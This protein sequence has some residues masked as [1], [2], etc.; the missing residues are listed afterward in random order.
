MKYI[1]YL[2]VCENLYYIGMTNNFLRRIQQHNGILSGGAK[3][4]KQKKDWNPIL[5][6]DGFETKSEAMQCEWGFKN[7]RGYNLKGIEGRFK[8]L[9]F[10]LNKNKW[11]NQSRFIK[12]Q[13][14]KI[15]VKNEYKKNIKVSTHELDW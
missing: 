3:F 5:I 6:I 14:L 9:E 15:Y 10:L 7:R 13:N 12:D 8:K 1:V 4:T 2:I 11:T